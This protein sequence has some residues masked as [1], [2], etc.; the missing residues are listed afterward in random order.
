MVNK[1]QCAVRALSARTNGPPGV[2]LRDNARE[3]IYNV[4]RVWHVTYHVHVAELKRLPE[5]SRRALC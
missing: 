2:C 5:D 3:D 1:E 4:A